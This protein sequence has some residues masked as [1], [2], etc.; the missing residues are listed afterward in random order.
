MSD[1]MLVILL[2][3]CL[4]KYAICMNQRVLFVVV[5]DLLWYCMVSVIRMVLLTL[6]KRDCIWPLFWKVLTK[7]CQLIALLKVF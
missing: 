5:S 2:P 1:V 4:S 7:F 6:E 3:T